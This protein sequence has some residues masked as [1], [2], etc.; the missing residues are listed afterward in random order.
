MTFAPPAND[1]QACRAFRGGPA[2][3]TDPEFRPG[4]AVMEKGDVAWAG[5]SA[6]PDFFIMMSQSRGFGASH[7]VW[8][9]MADDESMQLALKLVRGK[10]SAP[11]GQMRIL[12]EPVR[13]ILRDVT[14]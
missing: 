14:S 3:C 13:F 11:P 12:D 6:G 1:V 5:G 7:T 9:S 8:G 2:E 10:S 4:G